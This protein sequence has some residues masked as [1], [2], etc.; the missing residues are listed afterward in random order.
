MITSSTS[1]KTI[2]CQVLNNSAEVLLLDGQQRL[3]RMGQMQVQ[4]EVDWI[5]QHVLVFPIYREENMAIS[6]AEESR[7]RRLANAL[8]GIL[9]F[10]ITFLNLVKTVLNFTL[11]FEKEYDEKFIITRIADILKVMIG[12]GTLTSITVQFF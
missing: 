7:L 3:E 9:R 8:T 4:E 11:A 6:K 1:G 12:S 10:E 2:G 5:Q